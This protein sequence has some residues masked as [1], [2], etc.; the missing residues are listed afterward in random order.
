MTHPHRESPHS[1]LGLVAHIRRV[2]LANSAN[3]HRIDMLGAP[4]NELLYPVCLSF[5]IL[6]SRESACSFHVDLLACV[7]MV[8]ESQ[9]EERV[10]GN[11]MSAVYYLSTCFCLLFV[12]F[13][14]LLMLILMFFVDVNVNVFDLVFCFCFLFLFCFCFAIVKITGGMMPDFR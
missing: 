6:Q 11:P 4:S 10:L 3:S 9:E 2:N 7:G 5:D 1:N 13:C 8:L 12:L 14:F